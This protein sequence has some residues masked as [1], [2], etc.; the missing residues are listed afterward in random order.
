MTASNDVLQFSAAS[1]SV[2]SEFEI[3][4]GSLTV[5]TTTTPVSFDGTFGSGSTPGLVLVGGQLSALDISVTGTINAGGLA[6]S[7]NGLQFDYTSA[8]ST[9]SAGTF[10][11]VTGTVSVSTSDISFTGVFGSSDGTTTTP[12]LSMSGSTLTG[13][14]IAISSTINLENLSLTVD[15]LQF[16]YQTSGSYSGDYVIQSGS[17]SIATQA[18]DTSFQATFG[19]GSAPGLVVYNGTLENLYATV[20]STISVQGLTL[21]AAS[22][23]F[24]YQ[25]GTDTFEIYSGSVSITEGTLQFASATFGQTG[26]AGLT[27]QNGSLT[28]F[29]VSISSSMT[30]SGMSLTIDKLELIYTAVAGNVYGDFEIANGGSVALNAGTTGNTLSLSG[31]FG[32][33]LNN[34]VEPGLTISNGVLQSFYIAVTS[35]ISLADSLTLSTTGLTFAYAGSGNFQIPS[36]SVPW[37]IPR[38]TS[39]SPAHLLPHRQMYRRRPDWW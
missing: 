17:V 32:T 2:P 23:L 15:N 3:A 19:N 12:G 36:G 30:V 38:V 29:D 37:S 1:G 35:N 34:V 22:L 7:A 8:G 31:L 13:V 4:S 21:N 5:G 26:V 6:I 16:L 11:V 24:Q 39:T 27:I 28:G 9:A 18:G 33:T 25:G 14:D 10:Q 20:N